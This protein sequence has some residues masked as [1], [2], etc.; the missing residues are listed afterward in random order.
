[1]LPEMIAR[2]VALAARQAHVWLATA[3][4]DG[5]PH[6]TTAAQLIG[7]DGRRVALREWF[8]PVTVENVEQRPR[9]A[10]VVWPGGEADGYQ[11]IGRVERV[12]PHE[13]LD[14]YDPAL[15]HTAPLPQVERDLVLRVERVLVFR[16][17]PHTDA[18]ESGDDSR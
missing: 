5:Q 10:V 16:H 9:V 7:V 3:D 11:L 14:G 15:E 13:M 1:M 18:P 6:V 17:G 12:E 8:C 4:A 2:A